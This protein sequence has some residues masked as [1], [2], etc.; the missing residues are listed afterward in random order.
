M[1]NSNGVTSDD[2]RYRRVHK[3]G[4]LI[5]VQSNRPV[6]VNSE[7]SVCIEKVMTEHKKLEEI[8]IRGM[9]ADQIYDFLIE[10]TEDGLIRYINTPIEKMSGY[11]ADYFVGKRI[12]NFF[13][14]KF[15]LKQGQYDCHF[16]TKDGSRIQVESTVNKCNSEIF[17]IIFKNYEINKN[18]LF[19]SFVHELRNPINSLCQ[20]NDYLTIELQDIEQNY[21]PNLELKYQE[22]YQSKFKYINENQKTAIL[23]VKH[24]L[25]DFLD[26]EKMQT[27]TFVINDDEFCSIK[28]I[29]DDTKSI[30]DPYLYFEEKSIIYNCN[31]ICNEIVNIDKTRVCQVLIN[32]LQ[33]AIKYSKGSN[34]ELNLDIING[35]LKC[36]ITH[37]GDLDKSQI[38]SIFEPFYRVNMNKNDGTGLGLFICKNIIQKMK[39]TI[40]FINTN[41]EIVNIE[42]SLPI[43]ITHPFTKNK[44]ILIVDDFS[45]IRTTKLILETRGFNVDIVTSGNACINTC[46]TKVFDIILIDK[47]MNGLSGIDTVN[48][49]RKQMNYSGIIIGFTGDCFGSISENFDCSALGVNEII[50]KPLDIDYFVKICN[51]LL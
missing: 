7:N 42:F 24:L 23:H 35:F 39:G 3:N 17:T 26:F 12:Y 49:L 46:K 44:N 38:Q 25:N 11:N 5:W 29:I 19:R 22:I 27:N 40:D 36:N 21:I 32:L 16:I 51:K 45:G 48:I 6:F 30:I 2:I 47:N 14:N 50:F 31:N 9:C 1:Y 20:G 13:D 34:I 10:C 33:N 15:I 28:Q 41:I 37:S 43:R 18:E 4:S 8:S